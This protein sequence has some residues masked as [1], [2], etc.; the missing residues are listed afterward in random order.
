MSNRIAKVIDKYQLNDI[1]LSS[2]WANF[3]GQRSFGIAQMRGTGVLVLT[4]NEVFFRQSLIRAIISIP[5]AS[6]IEIKTPT[7][8]KGKTRFTPLLEVVFRNEEGEADSVAWQVKN[9]SQWLEHLNT[10]I[11]KAKADSSP[12]LDV[13]SLVRIGSAAKLRIVFFVLFIVSLPLTINGIVF[14]L[15]SIAGIPAFSVVGPLLLI[16]GLICLLCGLFFFFTYRKK[17]EELLQE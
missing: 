3:F 4:K 11:P 7:S 16:A 8:F 9:L 10:A 6:I 17:F 1:L 12:K 13:F 5:L 14:S 2:A 15:L